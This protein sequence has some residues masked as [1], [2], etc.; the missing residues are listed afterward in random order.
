[1]AGV[2]AGRRKLVERLLGG[3]RVPEIDL[4]QPVHHRDIRGGGF[5]A[6]IFGVSDGLVS[7]V[8]LVLGLAGAH[9]TSGI[10]RLA[11]L[12]GL[13]GGS[14]SMAAGEYVS[15]RGQHEVLERELDLERQELSRHPDVERRELEHIYHERGVTPDVARRVVE[16]LMVSPES[17]LTA[18]AR[19]ELGIDPSAL[20]SP[21]QA[22][23]AS[24]LTFGFGALVPLL[25]FLSGSSSSAAVLVAVALAALVALFVGFVLSYFTGRSKLY[26]ALR[27]LG[28]CAAAGGVTYLVGSLVGV[29][30]H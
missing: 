29:A 15:M 17:A 11:G 7:N 9:P 3:T 25:P 21:F 28:I 12:A 5:R 22:A 19:D 20:G 14:F 26:S 10:I 8:S 24:F 16:E 23:T 1:M 2:D 13:M 6:A 27:S 4:H 18:H 30:T